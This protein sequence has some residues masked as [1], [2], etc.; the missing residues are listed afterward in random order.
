LNL[1]ARYFHSWV[2]DLIQLRPITDNLVEIDEFEKQNLLAFAHKNVSE[3]QIYGFSLQTSY[4]INE[5]NTTIYAGITYTEGKNESEEN[6]P[7]SGIAPLSGLASIEYRHKSLKMNHQ[8]SFQFNNEKPLNEFANNSTDQRNY[9]LGSDG[10]PSWQTFN[11]RVEWEANKKI[12]L[13]FVVEN[14]LDTHYRTFGSSLNGLGRNFVV[15]VR[16]SL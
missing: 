6:E 7:L 13:Q 5:I 11:Y 15:A 16:G 12:K 10:A 14:I 4:S 8:F 1:T 9:F 3:S 2:D